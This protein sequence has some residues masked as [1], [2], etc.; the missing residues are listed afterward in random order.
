MCFDYFISYQCIQNAHTK[1]RIR[2]CFVM[3]ALAIIICVSAVMIGKRDVAAGKNIATERM[4][5]Y[6]EVREKGR[7]EAAENAERAQ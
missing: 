6:T 1:A 7:K 4:K 3:M 2:I 5:W